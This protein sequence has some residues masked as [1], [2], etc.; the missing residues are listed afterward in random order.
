MRFTKMNGIGND[1][2]FIDAT[3][4]E[5]RVFSRE[6][7]VELCDRHFGI[8]GDGIVYIVKGAKAR[9]GMKIFN[10]DGS[11]AEMCGNALRC[12]AK[13]LRDR[14]GAGQKLEI[15]TDAGLKTAEVRS[16]GKVVSCLGFA[17]GDF[18]PVKIFTDTEITGY[19]VSVGNPHFVIFCDDIEYMVAKYGKIISENAEFP[20]GTNVEFVRADIGN[21]RLHMRV[22]ERGTG[23]TLACGTGAAA[24]YET[25]FRAGFVGENAVI[26][27]K[28]GEL[29]LARDKGG[30]IIVT[31]N[32][33]Y[34]FDGETAG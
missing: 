29:Y 10:A 33:D 31:G 21:N 1:Y 34:N 4:G 14:K 18:A 23:E 3:D 16:D 30:E 2:I 32:A 27:L 7:T 28:G 22:Y 19:K 6:R 11:K 13:Y 9:Y 17:K 25:A 26:V 8:G 20:N 15:E 12:V 5:S 24:V